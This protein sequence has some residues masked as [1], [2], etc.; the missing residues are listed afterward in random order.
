[1]IIRVVKTWFCCNIYEQVLPKHIE[2]T[3]DA[4]VQADCIGY[5]DSVLQDLDAIQIIANLMRSSLLTRPEQCKLRPSE[6]LLLT[7]V[8]EVGLE[9]Q[10]SCKIEKLKLTVQ[11]FLRD[12][13]CA[14]YFLEQ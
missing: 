7:H 6:F 5:G 4:E 12:P 13:L 10:I 1:M 3:F 9:A 11:R 2:L 8:E 14:F